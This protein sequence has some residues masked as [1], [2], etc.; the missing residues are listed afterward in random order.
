MVVKDIELLELREHPE[1]WGDSGEV[2]SGEVEQL[3]VP[4]L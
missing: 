4:E 2:V 3:E 1:F